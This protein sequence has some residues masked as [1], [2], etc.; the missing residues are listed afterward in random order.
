MRWPPRA[1][2]AARNRA[3]AASRAGRTQAD[4]QRAVSRSDHRRRFARTAAAAL[5][6]T[7]GREQPRS[8]AIM[9]DTLRDQLWASASSRRP[10]PNARRGAQARRPRQ[11]AR[12]SPGRPQPRGK[13]AGSAAGA[14]ASGRRRPGARRTGQRTRA[15]PPAQGQATA[16]ARGHR[17]GQGLRDPRA[18]RKGRAHRGRGGEAGRSAPAPR[19]PRQADRAG[20]GQGAQ[21]RRRRDRPPFSVR[22]QD[23]A[24]LRHRGPAQGAQRRRTGRGAA[25]R[26]LRAGD[27]PN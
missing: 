11:A 20:Q 2:K 3:A 12:R 21:R 14:A 23:Q 9:S 4:A 8:L 18:E 15:A 19:G 6:I 16:H 13:P 1:T 22:R 26:P 24:H 17:P 7:S 25:G 27:A 5:L 10:S